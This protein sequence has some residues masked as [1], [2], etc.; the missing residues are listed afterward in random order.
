MSVGSRLREERLRLGM[1]Q[2]AFAALAGV[3]KGAVVKWEKDTAS[4]NALAL[5]AFASAGADAVYILTGRRS[6][7]WVTEDKI[8]EEDLYEIERDF[9][10]PAR[11]RLP[12]E[13]EEEA[14]ARVLKEAGD[15]LRDILRYDATAPRFPEKLIERVQALLEIAEN[16]S[17]LPV[18]RAADFAQ[19][20][21]EREETEFVLNIWFKDWP[22]KPDHLVM[23]QLVIMV[24]EY[25]VPYS[26]LVELTNS[27]Y[28]DIEEQRSAESVIRLHE[29]D[30]N[31]E[32]KLPKI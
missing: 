26:V 9:L 18:F 15:Q 2:P 3:T 20:R 27:V 30:T 7:S 29:P 12:D 13:S 16:P 5:N 11:K 25:G 8:L 6:P 19:K 1:S 4:P 21:G 23:K 14:L 32:K 17:R 31:K 22:Y 10:E 28:Q 24:I